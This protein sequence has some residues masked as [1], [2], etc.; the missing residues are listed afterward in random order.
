[1]KRNDNILTIS[2]EQ[3]NLVTGDRSPQ[4]KEVL[5]FADPLFLFFNFSLFIFGTFNF[6]R[7]LYPSLCKI[8]RVKFP[9]LYWALCFL[10]VLFSVNSFGQISNP[11]SP[12]LHH[13][14][15]QTI[16]PQQTIPHTNGH[17]SY[18]QQPTTP[19]GGTSQDII[20][21]QNRQAMQMMGYQPPV[22][23]P[24]D[25]ALAHQFI[26][27]QAQATGQSKQQRQINVLTAIV[28]EDKSKQQQINFTQTP[29]Y[30]AKT[31]NYRTAFA[32]V[33]KLYNSNETGSLKKVIFI[34]ENAYLDNSLKYETYNKQILAKV[35][36]L[37]TLMQ[38]E[39][40]SNNNDLG[41]NYLIQKLYSEKII[42]YKDTIIYRV[43]KP[44]LY[45]FDDFLGEK[46]WT[47][48]FVTKLLKTG[49][50]QCHS[51]PLLY[52]ILAEEIKAK[53]WLALAPEH[54]YIK[55]ADNTGRNILNFETTN[56]NAVSYDWLME[57]GYINSLAIK[58][59][60][61]LDTL[62]KN[63]LYATLLSDLVM[64]YTNK[65]GYDEFVETM[66]DTILKIHPQSVQG[67][68]FRA[69][70]LAL[71]TKYELKKAGKPPIEKIQQYP[72]ANKYYTAL[73]QHYDFIDGL[74]YQQMP[75]DKYAAWLLSLNDEKHKQEKQKLKSVIIGNAKTNN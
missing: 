31:A 55:F 32:E 19:M 73:M 48:M 62:G 59:N 17:T 58:N 65:F 23:P 16:N 29:E 35:K 12:S 27:Q 24:S 49:K 43:H 22:V 37:K 57:S 4:R 5:F 39:G 13:F 63:Q 75:K 40:I 34:I 67:L 56:G 42:E 10:T 45:D 68:I 38:K 18:Y 60:T 6:A 15:P 33:I 61:Y 14:Q 51:L 47:K 44:F 26:L 74:G 21:Q 2:V 66:V 25:P 11:H 7:H 9:T 30:L 70:L 72:E 41:K 54:S 64:G 3:T 1:M 69:D 8:K 71:L 36:L 28:N 52:L 50:G 53:A 46:D 20:N